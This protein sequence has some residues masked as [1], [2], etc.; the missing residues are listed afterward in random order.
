MRPSVAPARRQ[1]DPVPASSGAD[2][3]SDDAAAGVGRC[4]GP[5]TLLEILR[6]YSAIEAAAG[7]AR[8]SPE[9][10]EGLTRDE[11]EARLL[12]LSE[13]GQ[14][15]AAITLARRLYGYDLTQ[16][17]AFVDGLRNGKG[18]GASPQKKT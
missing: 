8:E 6:P 1:A 11:Q 17:K 3:V 9:S 15:M 16:A 10:F 7:T 12:E 13:T 18:S 4:S 2:G 14:G 5:E